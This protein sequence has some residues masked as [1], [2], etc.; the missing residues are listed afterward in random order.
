MDE[1]K[2]PTKFST[3]TTWEKKAGYCRAR[4]VGPHLYLAG[5]VAVDE[6]GQLVGRGDMGAQFH[7]CIDRIEQALMHFGADLS[8]VVRTRVYITDMSRFEEYAEAHGTRFRGIDP[9]NT[10]V[11]VSALVDPDMLVEV[12]VDAY[13]PS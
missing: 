6:Q 2:M 11:E 8:H 3:G 1:S 5:T 9:V 4:R 12:E 13:F 10:M 7:R